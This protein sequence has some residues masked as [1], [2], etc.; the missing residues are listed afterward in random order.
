MKNEIIRGKS[1]EEILE[2]ATLRKMELT[3]EVLDNIKIIEVAGGRFMGY[4][5]EV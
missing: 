1:I 4:T 5:K 3:P 2:G